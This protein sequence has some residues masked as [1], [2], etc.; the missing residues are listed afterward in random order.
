MYNYKNLLHV[1]SLSRLQRLR[2]RNSNFFLVILINSISKNTKTK[3]YRLES[4]SLHGNNL[5]RLRIR[6]GGHTCLKRDAF[7]TG[8]VG[9]K[10]WFNS[11]SPHFLPNYRI[12]VNL[13]P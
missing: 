9:E 10:A 7:G 2:Y 13:I 1:N 6:Y 5:I 11:P 8:K 12:G 3:F 4:F